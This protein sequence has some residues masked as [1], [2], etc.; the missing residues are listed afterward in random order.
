MS[1]MEIKEL[2]SENTG[3]LLAIVAITMTLVE[4]TP[5]KINPWSTFGHWIGRIFNGDVLKKLIL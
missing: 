3:T 5:I 4:I 1:L 2:L